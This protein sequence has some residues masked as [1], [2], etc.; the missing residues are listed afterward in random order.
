MVAVVIVYVAVVRMVCCFSRGM[1]QGLGAGK[2]C[3]LVGALMCAR[4]GTAGFPCTLL[5]LEVTFRA[6]R[7]SS[8]KRLTCCNAKSECF[9]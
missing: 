3:V 8:V 1:I 5:P 7:L 4:A 9:E 2:G 6:L